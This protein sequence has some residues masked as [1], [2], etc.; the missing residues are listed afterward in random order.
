MIK[1]IYHP[2][3]NISFLGLENL[4]P[5]DSKK[6]GRVYQALEDRFT[7]NLAQYLLTPA[8]PISQTELLTVHSLSYLDQLKSSRYAAQ[9]LEVPFLAFLP[10]VLIDSALLQGMRWATQ[11][12]ILGAKEALTSG[13]AINLSGG[14]HHA[15]PNSGEG[16]CAYADIALAVASVREAGLLKKDDK[17]VYIDLDAHQGN[18]VCHCFLNDDSVYIFDMYNGDI[19]PVDDEIAQARIDWNIPLTSMCDDKTY[20]NLLKSD[21]PAFLASIDNSGEKIGLV[22]YTAGTDVYQE[23]SLGQLGLSEAG[24]LERDMF[25]INVLQHRHIPTLMV[26]GGGYTQQ[27]YQLVFNTVQKILLDGN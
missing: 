1:I 2:G 3:Y 27:S 11:G 21:L 7:E 18:G 14:Y 26:L 16:F 19:Y 13:L 22:I 4:H 24:I 15:K 10:N 5:F 9:V 17:V 6:Y 12:T 20:L 23:D 25:V 8:Q